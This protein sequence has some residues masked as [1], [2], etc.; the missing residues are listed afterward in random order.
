MIKTKNLQERVSL[1]LHKVAVFLLVQ[2]GCI[3]MCLWCTEVTLKSLLM[4]MSRFSLSVLGELP[5]WTLGACF[6]QNYAPSSPPSYILHRVQPTLSLHPP[7]KERK[8]KKSKSR[9]LKVT[10]IKWLFP[11]LANSSSIIGSCLFVPPP[12]HCLNAVETE[13]DTIHQAASF[14]F[15]NSS[16]FVFP[17]SRQQLY[18]L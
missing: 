5:S 13:E 4:R 16:I 18:S 8:E 15:F 14:I 12:P 17:C 2:T 1:G 3:L 11:C 6:Q 7:H 9:G 10:F